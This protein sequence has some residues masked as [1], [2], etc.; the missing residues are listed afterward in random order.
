[1]AEKETSL[2][3]EIER[4]SEK[5]AKDPN[6]LVFAYLADA[7][8]RSNLVDEAIDIVK[9]GLLLHPQYSS[10]HIVLG[11]CYRDKRM[12]ELA[13]EEFEK[14]L[15]RDP[16]NLKVLRLSGD[17]LSSIGRKEEGMEKYRT[18]LEINPFNK[19]V[20]EIL[21][22]LHEETKPPEIQEERRTE[23]QDQKI[24]I[25]GL[26]I[27][28]ESP[29]ERPAE[30]EWK[31]G[32]GFLEMSMESPTEEEPSSSFPMDMEDVFPSESLEDFGLSAEADILHPTMEEGYTAEPVPPSTERPFLTETIAEIYEK[33]GFV[34]KALKIYRKLLQDD[35]EN[36]R[37]RLKVQSLEE[38]VSFLSSSEGMFTPKERRDVSLEDLVEKRDETPLILHPSKEETGEKRLEKLEEKGLE[39][40]EEGEKEEKDEEYDS[41]QDWLRGLKG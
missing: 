27:P 10:A 7:Y 5:L 24:E 8:R 40:K 2:D 18:L 32:S 22:R 20:K 15:E 34:E 23:L 29:M 41:F 37:L 14:V 25:P 16:Q 30:E 35:P 1:M 6:S 9:R 21:E 3:P 4:L 17:L 28:L 13:K 31:A 33:Q 11:C 26:N 39:E 19:E 38:G 36:E 12:Y